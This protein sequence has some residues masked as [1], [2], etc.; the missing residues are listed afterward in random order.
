MRNKLI[1]LLLVMLS[2]MLASCERPA[3]SPAIENTA[4]AYGALQS[5]HAV[6]LTYTF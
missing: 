1:H 5:G 3:D 4:L 6:F 2:A